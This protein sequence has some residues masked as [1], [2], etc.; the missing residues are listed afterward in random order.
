[1]KRNLV[2]VIIVSIAISCSSKSD[3]ATVDSDSN[4]LIELNVD[5]NAKSDL[6]SYINIESNDTIFL[7][8]TNEALIGRIDKIIVHDD[9]I[10]VL[11]IRVAKS[12]FIFNT[13]G[14]FQGKI[15]NIGDGPGQF[16]LPFDMGFNVETNRI[17]IMD[18]RLRKILSFNTKGG[19]IEEWRIEEQ[20]VD[21]Y[22]LSK[23]NYV[24]HRDGRKFE[25]GEKHNLLRL[26]DR[27]NTKVLLEGVSDFGVT[28]YLPI[29][30]N[31]MSTYNR[32]LY[33][34]PMHDTIYEVNNE[35]I[36]PAYFINFGNKKLPAEVKEMSMMDLRNK[37][38]TTDY[39][40]NMGNILET[41]DFVSF[42]WSRKEANFESLGDQ[43]VEEVFFSIYNK[44]NDTLITLPDN[45]NSEG[46]NWS[47]P[48]Y[49]KDD[50]FYSIYLPDVSASTIGKE[51]N[52][53]IVKYKIN[54]F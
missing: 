35:E 33:I 50:E 22:P 37:V 11:D 9:Q 31:L 52:P 4:T 3:N 28:D 5:P 8:T 44:N 48:V 45:Y 6:Q 47:Y 49:A 34:H 46:F 21:F 14:E 30:N 51:E 13:S 25:I 53:F 2:Y 12:I 16:F 38:L 26:S 20:L 32:L 15:N 43:A 10:F 7:E 24:F 36:R 19:F 17:E 42:L 41:S 1:M 23:D 54:K 29:N 39:Y 40:L 27:S 18:V